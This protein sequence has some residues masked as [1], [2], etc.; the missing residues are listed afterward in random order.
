MSHNIGLLLL[1]I[2]AEHASRI[3][4]GS[5]SFELRKSLPRASFSV[6][7]LIESGGRGVIGA[8]TAGKV[9]RKPVGELWELV[10]YRA[11]PTR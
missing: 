1:S 6:V 4:A 11:V 9:L 8:F 10:G 3:F 5:K 2:R 7:Y